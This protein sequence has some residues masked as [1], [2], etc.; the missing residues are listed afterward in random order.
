MAVLHDIKKDR[1]MPFSLDP[2]IQLSNRFISGKGL[3]SIWYPHDP[4]T[5]PDPTQAVMPFD[6]V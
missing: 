4:M 6:G 1:Y 2:F 3:L 5:P